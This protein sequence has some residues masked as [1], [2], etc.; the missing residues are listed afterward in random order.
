MIN[1]IRYQQQSLQATAIGN[2]NSQSSVATYQSREPQTGQRIV[3]T[4]EG[5]TA[6]VNYLSVNEPQTT[7]LILG[8]GSVGVTGYITNR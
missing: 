4:A 8:N 3:A 6:R 7:Q 2:L 5:G 1:Q